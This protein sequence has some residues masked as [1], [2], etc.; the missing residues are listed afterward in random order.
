[1]RQSLLFCKTKKES[2]KTAET[3]SHRLLIRADF[4]DQLAS[5]I[6]SFLPLGYK[7]LKKIEKIIREEME[8]IGGQELFLPTLQPKEI[9]KK[10][11][12]WEKMQ[13]P[14]FKLKDRHK[15]EFALGPTHEEVITKLAKGR[16]QSYKD[17]PI[18][19]FQIQNK[20][21]NELRFTGG[22][23]RTREFLMK[24]LY[25]FHKDEKESENY[26]K[27]VLRAYDKIFRRCGL[28]T[29][30]SEASGEAFTEKGA[31]TYEFQVQTEVGEDR[32]MFCKKCKFARSP[33][34]AKAKDEGLCPNCKRKLEKINTIEIGHC[35]NLGKKYSKAFNLYFVDGDGKRKLVTMG[36]YGIGLGRLMASIVEVHHDEKGISWPIGVAPF[37]VHL[38]PLLGKKVNSQVK[39]LYRDF[40]AKGI[41]V[42]FDDRADIT[43]GEKFADADLIGIPFRIVVSEK[44]LKRNSIEVKKRSEEKTKLIRI[45]QLPRFLNNLC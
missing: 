7:V 36:C 41:E 43:P 18:L 13:P 6:Y 20:F 40:Q 3:V 44:T 30:K 11:N 14:L 25:S 28:K 26:F 19:L 37:Q 8:R 31:R 5:G 45:K 10:T 38:I 1:M 4:I 17:L 21:R 32:I 29:I 42:L 39:R 16:I 12:R 27:K 34:I 15:K 24:D 22:L 33:E 9:W 2:P 23:L 35:F